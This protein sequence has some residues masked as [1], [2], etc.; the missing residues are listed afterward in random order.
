MTLLPLELQDVLDNLSYPG[1]VTVYERTGTRSTSGA[2]SSTA[3][4]SRTIQAVVLT[5]DVQE[6]QILSGGD[7]SG[8]GIVIHT[9]ETLYF[10]NAND[11]GDEL[12][13]S[14]IQWQGFTFRVVGTGFQSQNANFNTYIATRYKDYESDNG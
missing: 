6:L 10:Q 13:Q 8:G 14:F 4:T 3:G 9:P 11:A 5:A 12:R 2:W 1:G 7:V